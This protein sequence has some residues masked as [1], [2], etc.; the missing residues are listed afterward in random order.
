VLRIR[1]PPLK[2]RSKVLRRRLLPLEGPFR[3]AEKA[4]VVAGGPVSNLYGRTVGRLTEEGR[5]I[6]ACDG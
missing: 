5:E 3:G 1:L 2:E 4:A 6:L